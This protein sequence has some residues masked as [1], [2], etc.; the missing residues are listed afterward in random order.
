MVQDTHNNLNWCTFYIKNKVWLEFTVMTL[1]LACFIFLI[2]CYGRIF[3]EV[4][5]RIEPSERNTRKLVMT[6]FLLLGAFT[7]CWLPFMIFEFTMIIVLR[8]DTA[9]NKSRTLEGSH[10]F[11][12]IHNS[13]SLFAYF[14]KFRFNFFFQL[15]FSIQ[16]HANVLPPSGPSDLRCTNENCSALYSYPVRPF[17]PMLPKVYNQNGIKTHVDFYIF[18]DQST[19]QIGQWRQHSAT[20]CPTGTFMC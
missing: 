10:S 14:L 5:V 19:R 15:F 18:V 9:R 11:L 17:F 12:I 1:T 13:K 16:F 7:V 2:I 20:R 8:Q 4:F 6:T 3:K